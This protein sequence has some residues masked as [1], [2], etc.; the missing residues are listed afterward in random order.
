MAGVRHMACVRVPCLSCSHAGEMG[1]HSGRVGGCARAAR[2]LVGVTGWVGE[3]WVDGRRERER[4][5]GGREREEGEEERFR[6]RSPPQA[7]FE[8]VL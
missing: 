5:E 2:L 7:N 1:V 6:P 4:E 3:W 8:A